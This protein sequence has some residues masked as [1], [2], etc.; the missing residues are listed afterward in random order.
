MRSPGR[1]TRSPTTRCVSCWT[2]SRGAAPSV[3]RSATPSPRTTSFAGVT[4]T[5][6]FNDRGQR[7][8]TDQAYLVVKDRR[9]DLRRTAL[10]R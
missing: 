10:R 6:S 5:F 9:V 4:G 7:E 3:T 2:R 1:T 8:A